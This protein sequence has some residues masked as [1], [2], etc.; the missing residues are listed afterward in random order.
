MLNDTNNIIKKLN[1]I[2]LSKDEA[3]IYIALLENVSTYLELARNTGIS[4]STVYRN[5]ESLRLK[6]LVHVSVDESYGKNIA[7][8]DPSVLENLL[9]DKEINLAQQRAAISDTLPVLRQIGKQKI[10]FG[11]KVLTFE[12]VA[13]L[14]QMLWNELKANGEICIFASEVL[15]KLAGTRWAEKYRAQE[16]EKKIMHRALENP[17]ALHVLDRTKI[18]YAP[19]YK[20]RYVDKKILDI[21]QELS[22]HDDVVSI[23]NWNTDRDEIKIG[24]EVHSL[25]YAAF[26]KAIFETYWKLAKPSKK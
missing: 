5:I 19:F 22:I 23:Y 15:D 1:I 7:P 2:G 18:N 24:I 11:Y 8:A 17:D 10:D 20:V 25:Q 21:R 9:V 6:G 26:M 13:G 12:G 16:V 4:R 14:K 3:R